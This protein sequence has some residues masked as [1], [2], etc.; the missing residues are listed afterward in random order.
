MV[1]IRPENIWLFFLLILGSCFPEDER[2]EPHDPGDL[3]VGQV[4]MGS[5]YGQQVWYDLSANKVAS[6]GA[7]TDWDLSFDIT[8]GS[9]CIRLNSAR[10]MYAGNT[11]DTTFSQDILLVDPEMRFDKSDGNPDST[12]LGAW[13]TI[14]E[15]VVQS[16]RFV[17]LLDLGV[18]ARNK[19]QGLK[20]VQF[21]L[22]DGDYLIRYSDPGQATDTTVLIPRNGASARLYF[23][24]EDGVVDPAPLPATW[25]LL[26]TRYTTMLFTDL[27]EEYP[28]LVT[29]ALLNPEGVTAALDTIHEF[30]EITIADT[31]EL[32]LTP[33]AD[34]IG[35][36]WK[37]YDFDAGLYT[38]LPEF[39]YVIRDRDGFYYKLRFIDFYNDLGEKGHPKFEFIRL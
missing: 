15:E 23:S 39:T 1:K 25:S 17:Y 29:G 12:A 14:E 19:E 30:E 32:E 13:Y 22:S 3:E 31:T 5:F 20:K 8:P 11:F 18:D 38:I 37:Y 2:V 33:Q 21:D 28:Y 27:D 35:W 7:I 6:E 24:F 4:A 26:F 34:I 10:F 9:Y 16:R 36:E